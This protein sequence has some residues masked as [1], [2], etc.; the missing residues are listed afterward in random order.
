MKQQYPG[1][2]PPSSGF[3]ISAVPLLQQV[4][5]EIRRALLILLGA[6]GFVLLIACV[7]VAN[8]QLARAA[9]RQKEIA[10]RAAVGAGRRRIIRQLLNESVLLALMGGFLGLLLAFVAVRVLRVFGPDSLP[11]LNEIG[12]DD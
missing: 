5:G 2:Y 3:T 6:V 4:V 7:N 1:N 11:R 12:L 8:L 9:V 10:V